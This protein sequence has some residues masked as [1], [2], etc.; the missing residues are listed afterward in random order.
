[1]VHLLNTDVCFFSREPE[2]HVWSL[3]QSF[4]FQRFAS[5]PP[6][7][8]IC[9]HMS[10]VTIQK[11]INRNQWRYWWNSKVAPSALM[12]TLTSKFNILSDPFSA[13]AFA[14]LLVLLRF[15]ASVN[16]GTNANFGCERNFTAIFYIAGYSIRVLSFGKNKEKW[17]TFHIIVNSELLTLKVH[18]DR[19]HTGEKPYECPECQKVFRTDSCLN[20]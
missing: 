13:F 15:D 4:R 2:I 11:W 16:V 9:K 3:R 12:F 7:V 10:P 18:F 1:M 20:R 17:P 14:S 19:I 8:S 6:E 5:Y